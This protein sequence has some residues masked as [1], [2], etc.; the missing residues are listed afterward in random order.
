MEEISET[1]F[2][3]QWPLTVQSNCDE[4][5]LVSN[6]GKEWGIP[7]QAALLSKTLENLLGEIESVV[8]HNNRFELKNISSKTMNQ[9]VRYM[10][11]ALNF[12]KGD[13]FSVPDHL[14]RDVM[15]AS[16]FLD[17]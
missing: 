5:I 8:E 15:I 9:I 17:L 1:S 14:V 12:K 16:H 4:V 6:D 2:D 7:K 11:Y 3:D 13:H 10:K